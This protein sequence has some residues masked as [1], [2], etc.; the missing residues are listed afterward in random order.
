MPD[1][2]RYTRPKRI[3]KI[4]TRLVCTCC[5]RPLRAPLDVSTAMEAFCA[6]CSTP[7]STVP[8]FKLALTVA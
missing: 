6:T 3:A 5:R 8:V 2:R 7:N 4:P 1:D